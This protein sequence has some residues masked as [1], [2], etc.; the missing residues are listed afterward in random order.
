M[1]STFKIQKNNRIVRRWLAFFMVMLILSGMTAIPAD[2]ELSFV[3]R[4]GRRT[5][6]KP[7]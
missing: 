1:Q 7:Q 3:T 4:A 5:N 2:W 6:T